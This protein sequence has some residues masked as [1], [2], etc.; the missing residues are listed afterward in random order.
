MRPPSSFRLA[1]KKTVRARARRKG[2]QRAEPG[3]RDRAGHRDC[4]TFALVRSQSWNRLAEPIPRGAAS[5]GAALGAGRGWM[6]CARYP[7]ARHCEERSD[8]AI[9][10]FSGDRKGRPYGK[11]KVLRFPG[12]IQ[13]GARRP[14]LAVSIREVLRR[15][16]IRNLPLLSVF[17]FPT[18]LWTSKEKLICAEH[19]LRTA[20]NSR[21]KNASQRHCRWLEVLKF[22]RAA[23]GR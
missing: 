9:R 6:F 21:I 8:V 11:A 16:R 3:Y 12:G 2:R 4:R 17:S 13:E 1:E 22:L 18:F 19:V 15:G 20:N 5:L 7:F 23:S 14:P 10:S